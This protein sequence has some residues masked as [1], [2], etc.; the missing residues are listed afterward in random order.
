M[1]RSTLS[2][3][4]AIQ[5]CDRDTRKRIWGKVLTGAYKGTLSSISRGSEQEF[6]L[7]TEDL[8]LYYAGP[9]RAVTP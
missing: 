1:F 8:K 4:A 3:P 5:I 2:V 6:H 7:L 9:D